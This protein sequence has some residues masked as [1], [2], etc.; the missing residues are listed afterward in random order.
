QLDDLRLKLNHLFDALTEDAARAESVSVLATILNEVTITVNQLLAKFVTQP[1]HERDQ[2]GSEQ[3]ISYRH[4]GYLRAEIVQQNVTYQG[5]TK[6]ISTEGLGLKSMSKF[7]EDLPV[8]ITVFLP[9]KGE[10]HYESHTPLMIEGSIVH[11]HQEG[12]YHVYGIHII[13][14]GPKASNELKTAVC[15]FEEGSGIDLF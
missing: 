15:F 13:E 6:D 14:E 9:Q 1:C 12:D 8:S 3:R 4:K 11:H 10:V 5:A 7:D 2:E